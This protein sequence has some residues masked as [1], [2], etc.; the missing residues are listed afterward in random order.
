MQMAPPMQAPMQ[1]MMQA[2]QMPSA[3]HMQNQWAR[4]LLIPFEFWRSLRLSHLIDTWWIQMNPKCLQ[5]YKPQTFHYPTFQCLTIMNIQTRSQMNKKRFGPTKRDEILCSSGLLHLRSLSKTLSE[6]INFNKDAET[7]K[8]SGA[9][10]AHTVTDSDRCVPPGKN[11]TR[12]RS[13]QLQP[14]E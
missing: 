2:P 6:I 10:R 9:K 8:P 1:Q 5:T 13:N 11:E 14:H 3:P 12:A 7:I 4:R